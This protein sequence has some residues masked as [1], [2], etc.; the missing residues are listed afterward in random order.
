MK[1]AVLIV[2]ARGEESPS[3]VMVFE[4]HNMACDWMFSNR[5]HP[6]ITSIE[7]IAPELYYAS[8]APPPNLERTNQAKLL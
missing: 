1:S 8:D 6:S 5:S 7:M 2:H 3:R 4:D